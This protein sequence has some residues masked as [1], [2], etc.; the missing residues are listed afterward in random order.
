VFFEWLDTLGLNL[1]LNDE[2]WLLRRP[3]IISRGVSQNDLERSLRGRARHPPSSRLPDGW[4]REGARLYVA[5]H[6]YSEAI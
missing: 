3:E 1:D 2:A 5:P 4:E 6:L